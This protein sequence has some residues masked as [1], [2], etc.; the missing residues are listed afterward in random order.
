MMPPH[1]IPHIPLAKFSVQ[2]MLYIFFP[3]LYRP[4]RPNRN[5]LTP[6][7]LKLVYERG[8]RPAAIRTNPTAAGDWP[9][10][11]K[12]EVFRAQNHGPGFSFTTCMVAA[13]DVPDFTYY[14]RRYLADLDWGRD[15][16]FMTQIRGVKLGTYHDPTPQGA[17]EALLDLTED[18]L[19]DEGIWY[20]DVGLEIYEE[21][22]AYQWASSSHQRILENIL[23]ITPEDAAKIFRPGRFYFQ[24][25][26]SHFLDISGFRA[27][28]GIAPGQQV[29]QYIQCYTVDK[30]VTYHPDNRGHFAKFM[31]TNMAMQGDPPKFVS[32]L[33]EA[34]LNASDHIDCAARIEVRLPIFNSTNVLL[35]LDPQLVQESL[36]RFRR[37]LWW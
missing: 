15:V 8:I 10:T 34:Y 24:D 12:D 27:T 3:R 2:H 17:Q 7:E 28:T 23:N 25:I 26:S 18:L 31:T 6:E 13:C 1:Q 16:L 14:L 22:Y 19:T 5:N 32:N 35:G 37:K 36:L 11:Y 9:A 30:S 29:I 33:Y 20:I 21:R 4:D